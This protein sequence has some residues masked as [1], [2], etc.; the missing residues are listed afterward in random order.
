MTKR[1]TEMKEKEKKSPI[2]T[3][4]SERKKNELLEKIGIEQTNGIELQWKK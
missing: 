1:E 3:S 2:I 4:E